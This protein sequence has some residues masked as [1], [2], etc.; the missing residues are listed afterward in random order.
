LKNTEE[1]DDP[2]LY[3]KENASFIDDLPFLLKWAS[4]TDGVIID[5]ACGTVSLRGFDPRLS[6]G[7]VGAMRC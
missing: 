6:R 4:K 7:N 5:L 2:I 3:D 1:Y